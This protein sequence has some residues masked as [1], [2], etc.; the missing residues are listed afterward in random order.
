M[1][2]FLALASLGTEPILRKELK[3]LGVKPQGESAPGRVFFQT[4]WEGAY[5]VLL[6]SRTADRILFLPKIFSA[7]NFE[8]L[9]QGLGKI[10]WEEYFSAQKGLV[11]AQIRSQ[12]SPLSSSPVLQKTAA[13]AVYSR[14]TQAWKIQRLPETEDSATLR[15]FI[16]GNSIY[17]GID[18]SG[19]GL[20]RRGFK[21][22]KGQAP[23]KETLAACLLMSLG[24]RRKTPLWDP[25]CGSGTF[26]LE[27]LLYAQN[28][29]PG[30]HRPMALQA[31]ALF[32]ASLWDRVL[33]E[34][35]EGIHYEGQFRIM[36]SDKDPAMLPISQANLD[37]IDPDHGIPLSQSSF[38]R[39]SPAPYP[40]GV[41][42][43]NPPYG[44]R[45]EN[46][47]AAQAIHEEIG[48]W[49]N[50]HPRWGAGIV[51]AL[52]KIPG[53]TPGKDIE[54]KKIIA[55]ALD[56]YFFTRRSS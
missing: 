14:L 18:L 13:K 56:L 41:L 24:W 12:K 9:F 55:G 21:K 51:T 39:H 22:E 54:R 27:A 11:I 31:L 46:K 50:A 52:P 6:N 43:C 37:R 1:Q 2:D 44:L 23:L 15:I 36:G 34:A 35:R 10:P 38:D 49:L 53:L 7:W 19:E 40:Q 5:R 47:L 29:P 3:F 17:P 26:L 16:Q 28:V 32:D 48:L 30:I 25:F 33:T 20:H 8:Q 4:D 42:I 45:L